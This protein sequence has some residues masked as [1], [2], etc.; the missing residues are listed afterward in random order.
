MRLTVEQDVIF[1]NVPEANL[2]A[3]QQVCQ[4]DVDK[5]PLQWSAA[6][7]PD[8]SSRTLVCFSHTLIAAI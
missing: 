7:R 2:E 5:L 4:P 6:R 3:M 1:P 8:T